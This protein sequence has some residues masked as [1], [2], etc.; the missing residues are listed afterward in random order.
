[1]AYPSGAWHQTSPSLNMYSAV[2][3]MKPP[4][5]HVAANISQKYALKLTIM[6]KAT[7]YYQKKR[8]QNKNNLKKSNN[9]KQQS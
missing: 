7:L 6:K 2:P 4:P 3:L 1:M 9:N 8:K 5:T